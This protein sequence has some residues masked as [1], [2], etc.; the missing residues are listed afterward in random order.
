MFVIS[1]TI[2]III[3]AGSW[4][5]VDSKASRGGSAAR[6]GSRASA[7]RSWRISLSFVLLLVVVVIV[8]VVISLVILLIILLLYHYHIGRP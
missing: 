5:K 6:S 4:R 2:N 8:V 1:I 7:W 3:A